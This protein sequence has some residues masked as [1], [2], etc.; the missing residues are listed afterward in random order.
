MAKSHVEIRIS[1]LKP[2]NSCWVS[3]FSDTFSYTNYVYQM[4]PFYILEV[5]PVR[6][7]DIFL[8]GLNLLEFLQIGIHD[9]SKTGIHEA[10]Y[11]KRI[12]D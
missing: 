7:I 11:S 4:F 6:C 3:D 9:F 2:R 12:P 8:S 5:F 10:S 1:F